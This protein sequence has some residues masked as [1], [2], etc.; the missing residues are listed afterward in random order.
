MRFSLNSLKRVLMISH[1]TFKE[2]IKSKILLNTLFLGFAILTITYVALSFTYG[3]A[4]KISLDFGLGLLT[5]SSIGIAIFIGVGLLSKEIESRTVYMVI[6]RPV[7]R[8]EFI[9]GKILGLNL[10]LMLNIAILS[11]FTYL[12]YFYIGGVFTS[13]LI[14]TIFFIMLESLLVLLLVCLLSLITTQT[15]TVIISLAV[16]VTSHG[17][18]TAL[19]TSFTQSQPLL[20]QLLKILHYILPAFYKLNIKSFLLYQQEIAT[21]Y[22]LGASLHTLFYCLFL[23]FLCIYVFKTKDLN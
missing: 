6:S 12:T 10:V 14:W 8:H 22:L 3:E 16:Y 1:Y 9:I 4:T 21:S 11:V 18:H 13:L 5:M 23:V 2:I 19:K 15:L 20:E 17:I 7:K